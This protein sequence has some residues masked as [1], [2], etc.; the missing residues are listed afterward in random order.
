MIDFQKNV[1]QNQECK[2]REMQGHKKTYEAPEFDFVR[3]KLEDVLNTT[4]QITSGEEPRPELG[5]GDMD[6]FDNL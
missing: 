2:E 5:E 3:F 1:L 4:P 6:G